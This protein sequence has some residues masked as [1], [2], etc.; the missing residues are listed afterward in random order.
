MALMQLGL[1]GAIPLVQQREKLI[2]KRLSATPLKRSAFIGSNI[3]MRLGI[4]L[5]QMV[6]IVVVGVQLFGVT[7]VGSLAEVVFLVVLGALMFTSLGYV[8]AS[9]VPTEETANMVTSILQFPLM[10]LSG[11]FFPLELMPALAANDR[12]AAAVDVPRRRAAPGDGR[13]D[14]LRADRRQRG[15]AD[16][17][18]DRLL[19]DLRALLPLAV[20]GSGARRRQIAWRTCRQSRRALAPVDG[21]GPAARRRR[22]LRARLAPR[23]PCK[24]LGQTLHERPS[25]RRAL[26]SA[27]PGAPRTDRTIAAPARTSALVAFQSTLMHSSCMRSSVAWINPRCVGESTLRCRTRPSSWRK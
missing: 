25:V 27:S 11:I 13:R 5:V 10:F 4:G 18:A 8:V 20:T 22:L 24:V 14:A 3:V 23:T 19:R 15:G 16:W 9:F 6:L 26:A 7:I 2:L 21:G 12:R 17:L 1:F